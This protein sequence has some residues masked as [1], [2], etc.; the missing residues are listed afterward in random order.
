MANINLIMKVTS[1]CT[2]ACSYCQ[3]M[4]DLTDNNSNLIMSR[5]ILQ[6]SISQLMSLPSRNVTFI[7]HGGEPLLVGMDF[8]EEAICLQSQHQKK[9]AQKIVNNIQTNATLLNQEWINFLQ[10]SNFNI[11]ISLD[12]PSEIHKMHRLSPS[13]TNSFTHIMQA[14]KL[15]MDNK[16]KFGLLAVVTKNSIKKP[17]EIYDFFAHNGFKSF[18]FLPCIEIKKDTGEMIGSSITASEFADFMIQ[19][20]DLWIKDDNPDIHIRYFDNVLKGLLGGKPTLCKF[21]GTCSNFITIACNGDIYPCDNFVG[22]SALKF[23]NILNDDLQEV[24]EGGKHKNFVEKINAIK[25][26][27]SNC[28][29]YQIC[30][31]GCPYYSYMLGQDFSNENYFCE[32][33]KSILKHVEKSLKR[34]INDA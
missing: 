16:L 32:A 2:L 20:F 18:D 5:E 9:D 7:W 15:L 33:R 1:K 28:E 25:P 22:Y 34:I 3:Y 13:G 11:S 14:V 10:K 26:E 4:A 21:A 24:I 6:R 19:V 23:G 12:G 8:Y 17:K 29:W 30:R 27:C 31:G